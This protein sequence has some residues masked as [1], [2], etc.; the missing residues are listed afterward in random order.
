MVIDDDAWVGDPIAV[1]VVE[2]RRLGPP[3][4]LAGHPSPFATDHDDALLL[5]T[6]NRGFSDCGTSEDFTDRA[7]FDHVPMG[8]TSLGIVEKRAVVAAGEVVRL[9][10]GRKTTEYG[11]TT[12]DADGTPLS[13]GRTT[14]LWHALQL[15]VRWSALLGDRPL[16]VTTTVE[17]RAWH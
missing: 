11:V 16:L 14:L 7:L 8:Y 17:T 5:V 15:A 10:P 2:H 3:E 12:V 9:W 1:P 4:W 13:A 6:T